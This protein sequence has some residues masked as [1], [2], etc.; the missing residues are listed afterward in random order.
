V[1]TPDRTLLHDLQSCAGSAFATPQASA[2]ASA[3]AARSARG[4]V[5]RTVHLA[6]VYLRFARLE[7]ERP[8]QDAAR[9]TR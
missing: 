6:I 4:V 5:F 9:R 1:A 3:A 2:I 8:K 7:C